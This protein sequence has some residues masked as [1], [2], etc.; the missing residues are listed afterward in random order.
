MANSFNSEIS[1]SENSWTP[2]CH[3]SY[4]MSSEEAFSHSFI[5]KAEALSVVTS[6]M[7]F[8][9][10]TSA[11][12]LSISDIMVRRFSALDVASSALALEGTTIF[13]HRRWGS[14]FMDSLH[15]GYHSPFLLTPDISPSCRSSLLPFQA[16]FNSLLL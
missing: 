5:F 7:S 15:Y 12:I 13:F 16:L 14:G 8:L 9:G 3:R 10:V 11:I 2:R 6:A 4:S 1:S